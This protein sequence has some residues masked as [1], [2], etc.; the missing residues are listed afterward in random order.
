MQ[1]WILYKIYVKLLDNIQKWMSGD[2]LK[3]NSSKTE[4][5]QFGSRQ[6]LEKLHFNTLNVCVVG[7]CNSVNCLVADNKKGC[8]SRSLS[9][10]P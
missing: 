2:R 8:P 5:I 4:F 3:M 7:S 10:I 1:N 9:F 6:Q